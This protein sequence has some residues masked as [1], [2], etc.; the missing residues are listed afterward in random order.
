LDDLSSDEFTKRNAAHK[1]LSKFGMLAETALR[2]RLKAN[3][4][5]EV[6]Q[7]MEALLM[8]IETPRPLDAEVLQSVRG[9]AVLS[10]INS[11]QARQLLLVLAKG[12][13]SAPVTRAASAAL[14]H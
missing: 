3:P 1:Q 12:V 14:R 2:E 8:P 4:P 10:Q 9:V 13:E 5:L 6:R 7:R 11:P